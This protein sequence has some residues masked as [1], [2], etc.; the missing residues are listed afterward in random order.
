MSSGSRITKAADDAAGLAISEKLKANIKSNSQANRNANDG[1]SMVQTAE[2][3]LDEISN[4]LTRLRELSI[5]SASDT[6]GDTERGFSDMEYQNLKQ[7]IERISQVTEFNGTKLLSGQGDK[8]DFQIGI[9][10][11]DFQDRISYDVQMTNASMG[12]LG[13]DSISVGNKEGAQGALGTIDNAIEKVSGQRAALGAIQ[14]RL[15]STSNNLQVTN[16]NLSAAN[17]RIRDV[18]YADVAAKNAKNNIL[19]QAG[20][21]VLAQAN[22]QGQ[23]AL[24][25]IG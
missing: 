13:I 15:I 18:D 24:R 9:N 20:T 3:G 21:S 14:N 19:A 17:S 22:A 4:M 2:G 8:L 12:S 6:V 16:E 10:N 11:D 7:E 1:I 25:L 23:N 5:Q